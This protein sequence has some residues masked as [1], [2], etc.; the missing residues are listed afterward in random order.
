MCMKAIKCLTEKIRDIKDTLLED[1]FIPGQLNMCELQT[2]I[3]L[4]ES[5][6]A[7]CSVTIEPIRGT[8]RVMLWWVD[9]A[10]SFCAELPNTRANV[11]NREFVHVLEQAKQI[12]G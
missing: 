12:M 11:S 9:G 1:D 8:Q 2:L 4:M 7:T 10:K 3:K 6:S 5:V